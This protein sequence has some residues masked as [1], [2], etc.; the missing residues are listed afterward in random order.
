MNHFR[1]ATCVL[2]GVWSVAGLA[3][4]AK[5]DVLT[6]L[7]ACA[8][9]KADAARLSCYDAEMARLSQQAR[10]DAAAPAAALSA[11]E[12]FGFRGEVAREALDR[13]EAA[14]P[15]LEQLTAAITA[16]SSRPHGELVVTLANGQVWA[17]KAVESSFRLKVGDE[18]TIKPGAL[19]SFRLVGPT[20]RSTQVARVR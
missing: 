7:R 19:A 13:Q 2:A 15:R 18:V 12:R 6:G 11:E 9:E 14:A 5:Q 1:F 20:G 10:A 8:A 17:Q 4:E 3:Q 16:I